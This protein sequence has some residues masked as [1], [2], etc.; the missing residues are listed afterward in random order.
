MDIKAARSSEQ[1]FGGSRT[2][3]YWLAG[4]C[5]RNPCRF[6]HSVTPSSHQSPYSSEHCNKANT[7]YR[8][9]RKPPHQY[10]SELKTSKYDN[11]KKV[12]I[13]K[14]GETG[15]GHEMSVAKTFKRPSH[16]LCTYWVNGNC[17]HHDKCPNLHS[18][19]Y[20]DGFSTLA[21]LQEHKKVHFNCNMH[22]QLF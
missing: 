5:R 8:H 18:W 13:T 7:S 9:T 11:S 16:S 20:G 2:C 17:V 22:V 15:G 6:L 4:R 19:F 14:T 12:L 1:H 10:S 3:V 21:K